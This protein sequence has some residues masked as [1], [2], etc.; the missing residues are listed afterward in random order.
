MLWRRVIRAIRAKADIT[1]TRAGAMDNRPIPTATKQPL[2]VRLTQMLRLVRELLRTLA[3]VAIV[4]AIA[5]MFLEG[6]PQAALAQVEAL[7]NRIAETP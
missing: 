2:T 6:N 3:L 4:V 7:L 1:A 5:W